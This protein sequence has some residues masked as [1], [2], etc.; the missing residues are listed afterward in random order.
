[1]SLGTHFQMVVFGPGSV[2]GLRF[3]DMNAIGDGSGPYEL[4]THF[5]PWSYASYV[6][7]VNYRSISLPKDGYGL[8]GDGSFKV[9]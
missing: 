6:G 8:Y 1:M 3:G 2:E 4:N 7:G 5:L 9:K